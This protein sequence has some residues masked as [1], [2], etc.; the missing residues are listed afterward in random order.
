MKLD[1]PF[2]LHCFI[3][4]GHISIN[5]KYKVG[6]FI[7]HNRCLYRVLNQYAVL[8]IGTEGRAGL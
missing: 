4:Y 3:A 6:L 1:F 2:T 5:F 7:C 8:G